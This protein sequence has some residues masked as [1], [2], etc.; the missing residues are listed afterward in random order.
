MQP[1]DG[2]WLEQIRRASDHRFDVSRN[3]SVASRDHMPMILEARAKDL[4]SAQSAQEQR[5]KSLGRR[6]RLM[7]RQKRL[8]RPTRCCAR[9]QASI[10]VSWR[11]SIGP[12]ALARWRRIWVRFNEAI[13]LAVAES[14]SFFTADVDRWR[15][16]FLACSGTTCVGRSMQFFSR[17][18]CFRG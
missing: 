14:V 12:C 18:S 11:R 16:V 2:A 1:I 4:R 15:H 6:P 9:R 8:P 10:S 5:A 13:D 17:P 3:A 7:A